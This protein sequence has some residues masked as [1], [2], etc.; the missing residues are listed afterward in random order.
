M[1]TP[2]I[3]NDY[4]KAVL[5]DYD[6]GEFA[7]LIEEGAI[8]NPLG[9]GDTLLSFMLIELSDS[10]GCENIE[11]AWHRL[12]TAKDEIDVALKALMKIYEAMRE[13]IREG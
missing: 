5:A 2:M 8:E 9:L 12:D 6:D 4:Q 11:I 7:H 3:L 1:N 13:Q 10:E